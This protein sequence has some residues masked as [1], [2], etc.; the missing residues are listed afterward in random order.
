MDRLTIRRELCPLQRETSW[1]IRYAKYKGRSVDWIQ[2]YIVVLFPV[3]HYFHVNIEHGVSAG[4]SRNTRADR[5]GDADLDRLFAGGRGGKEATQKI[6]LSL[7]QAVQQEQG[8]I[9]VQVVELDDSTTIESLVQSCSSTDAM[10]T[11]RIFDAL[12]C[13]ALF[14]LFG[15]T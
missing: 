15:L 12:A 13:V 1:F 11:C 10:A 3:I 8:I 5:S 2:F 9:G 6:A 4:A 14:G 7:W